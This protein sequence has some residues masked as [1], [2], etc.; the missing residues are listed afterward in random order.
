MKTIWEAVKEGS[1]RLTEAGIENAEWESRTLLCEQLQLSLGSFLL[2]RDRI[3]PADEISDFEA[4]VE[5]RC[6]HIPMQHILGKACFYGL[7]FIVTPDVLIPRPETE[8]L[9]E[10][11]IA[12]AGPGMHVLDLCTGSGCI[13]VTV[14]HEKPDVFVD[15]SDVSAPALAIARQ[16]AARHQVEIRWI[17]SDLFEAIDRQYDMILSNPP[18]ISLD[19][20]QQLMPEVKDHDPSLAL[21]GGTDGLDYYRRITKDA[22]SRLKPGGLLMMEIGA[23][24]G[25]DVR[26]LLAQN[27][28]QEIEVIRD[29]NGLDRIAAGRSV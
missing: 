12:A 15:A 24:Q 14:A 2:Q 18:Y 6:Q 8:L 7:D 4:A 25:A 29:L 11:A 21:Y 27:G 20:M 28:Y 16:N 23:S 1:G 5:K 3:L 13:A 19:E 9:A 10:R 22:V 26:A 17:Q